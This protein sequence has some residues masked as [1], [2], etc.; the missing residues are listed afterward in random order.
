ML[1]FKHFIFLPRCT[2]GSSSSMYDHGHECVCTTHFTV[3]E[4]ILIDEDHFLLNY[5]REDRDLR[6]AF[7]LSTLSLKPL[8]PLYLDHVDIGEM[9][10][11]CW[12]NT[13]SVQHL[14]TRKKNMV[15]SLTIGTYLDLVYG[16]TSPWVV[17]TG[18]IR[19]G[20]WSLYCQ[21]RYCDCNFYL[22][23]FTM[24]CW[25]EQNIFCW[26]GQGEKHEK[27]ACWI[28]NNVTKRHVFSISSIRSFFS[29]TSCLTG[30]L[31][32]GGLVGS[33]FDVRPWSMSPEN[34]VSSNS[35]E[36]NSRELDA[37]FLCFWWRRRYSLC[38]GGFCQ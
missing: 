29:C 30:Y 33:I 5:K 37:F 1:S 25:N 35:K 7:G 23:F 17:P 36:H 32:F 11:K 19:D 34:E 20:P 10:E 18:R 9:L 2:H 3:W 28:L 14:Y 31:G 13:G 12:R 24:G 4:S 22:M 21:G 38:C 15:R 26:N 8:H 16:Y 27:V 6:E